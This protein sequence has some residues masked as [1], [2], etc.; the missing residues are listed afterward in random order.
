MD[1]STIYSSI[2]LYNGIILFAVYSFMGWLIEVV[3]RSSKQKK[4]INAG[5]LH[6]PFV[7]IYGFGAAF[8]MLLEYFLQPYGV[9]VKLLV[10]GIVLT[11]VEYVVGYLF[12]TIFK[13]KLWDYS[14]NAFNLHGRIC[15]LFSA[16]WT[17]FAFVFV[18]MI[19]PFVVR[20]IVSLDDTLVRGA[21]AVFAVYGIVDFV[22]SVTSITAFRRT[23]AYLYSE[24][25]NLSNV[26][27]EKIFD[28]FKRLRSAFPDLDRYIDKNIN[29]EIRSRI[30][31]FMKSI[32]TKIMMDLEGRK[33]FEKEFYD[34]IN[35]I[36][37]H[38]E[39]MKLKRFFHHNSS[40]YAHARD[41]A[42]FTYRACKYLKL[43]YRS[44]TRGALL[45]DFFLYDWRNHDEPDLHRDK[46][47]GIEHPRIA[48]SNAEK[49]FKLNDIEKDIIV[50]H[51]WPLTLVP[52][53]YKESYIVTFADKYLSSKEFIDEFKRSRKTGKFR[54][55]R[56]ARN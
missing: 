45:H 35:D 34:I 19:N 4:F 53:K 39:F 56:R 14:D 28:S 49:Y 22:M 51:M 12:E 3:Y 47:H 32:Q 18:T 43:D 20:H 10:Y 41:V 23:I 29:V 33:P 13:L 15:L 46:Y 52:P 16:F 54:N 27:I 2:S 37:K 5:F 24:Y 8:I 21:A 30:S 25:F 1:D 40:I 11:M 9:L 31:T 44:A 26:E 6:G 36:Y 55:P 38:E 17:I 48:L 50:K 42:Y 7:P